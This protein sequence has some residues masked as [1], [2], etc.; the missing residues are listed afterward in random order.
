MAGIVLFLTPTQPLLPH[1]T[2]SDG[3]PPIPFNPTIPYHIPQYHSHPQHPT[4]HHTPHSPSTHSAPSSAHLT[5]HSLTPYSLMHSLL[6][7]LIP[8]CS[9][10]TIFYLLSSTST[11]RCHLV[12]ISMSS[13]TADF[14][15]LSS[16]P[17]STS[18]IVFRIVFV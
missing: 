9:L 10:N 14:S 18:L 12:T 4:P 2:P 5:P 7:Y 13:I 3:P 8:P 16:I 6:T 11:S 17:L 15:L 1:P